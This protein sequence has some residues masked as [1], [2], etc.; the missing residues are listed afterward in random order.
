MK[1]VAAGDWTKMMTDCD[2]KFR[3]ST[4]GRVHFR[5]S[6]PMGRRKNG[7]SQKMGQ[8]HRSLVLFSDGT[9]MAIPEINPNQEM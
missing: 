1:E 5:R 9:G 3:G 7:A 8:Q 4:F 6:L 2:C